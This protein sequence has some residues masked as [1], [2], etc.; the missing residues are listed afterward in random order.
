[1]QKAIFRAATFVRCSFEKC[2]LNESVFHKARLLIPIFT[3]Q[4]T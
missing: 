4:Q 1:L 3:R 2:T